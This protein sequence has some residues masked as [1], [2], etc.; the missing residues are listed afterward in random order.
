MCA[1]AAGVLR[2]LGSQPAGAAVYSG[3]VSFSVSAPEEVRIGKKSFKKDLRGG[4]AE[5][6]LA[7]VCHGGR[8][9]A[10]IGCVWVQARGKF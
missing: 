10:A 1:E 8:W 2:V 3:S 9:L 4:R 5:S 7:I 6:H